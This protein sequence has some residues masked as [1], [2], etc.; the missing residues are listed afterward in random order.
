MVNNDIVINLNVIGLLMCKETLS[1]NRMHDWN[2]FK[3]PTFNGYFGSSVTTSDPC[4]CGN[5]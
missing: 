5:H 3:A 2:T 1:A 4:H